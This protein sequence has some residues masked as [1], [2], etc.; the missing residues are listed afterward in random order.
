[1]KLKEV[2]LLPLE[3]SLR[4]GLEQTQAIS[5]LEKHF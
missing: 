5:Q 3:P 4:K 1:M 2:D